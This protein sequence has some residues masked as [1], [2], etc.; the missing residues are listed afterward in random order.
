MTKKY[1]SVVKKTYDFLKELS[2]STDKPI[3]IVA[4]NV[5]MSHDHMLALYENLCPKGFV[6]ME[7]NGRNKKIK[8]THEGMKLL[9]IYEEFIASLN[10]CGLDLE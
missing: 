3:S 8:I 7:E 10:Q 4:R 9:K 5:N 6:S 2:T 1:R